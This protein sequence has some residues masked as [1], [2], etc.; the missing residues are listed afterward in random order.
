MV[1]YN[2][3]YRL[4]YAYLVKI[5]YTNEMKRKGDQKV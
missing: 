2:K 4:N 5:Y 1:I 3:L